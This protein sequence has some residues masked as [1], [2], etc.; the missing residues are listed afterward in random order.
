MFD[1]DKA[2]LQGKTAYLYVIKKTVVGFCTVEIIRSAHRLINTT[3]DRKTGN[4]EQFRRGASASSGCGT[5]SVAQGAMC[6]SVE[7]ERAMMGVH[8]LWCHR[9]Q[10]R[11]GVAARLV[12]AARASFV[13]GTAVPQHLV[14]FSS[15]TA[16]G[17]RFAINYLGTQTPLVYDCT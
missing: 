14:A 1:D 13:Y 10:R 12:D 2:S 16:D 8:Q 6:R 11:S 3:N 7:S 4:T 15:P 9:I 5:A 17:L